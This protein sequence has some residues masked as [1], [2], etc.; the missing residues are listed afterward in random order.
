MGLIL[1]EVLYSKLPWDVSTVADWIDNI[2]KYVT[3]NIYSQPF[4]F[5]IRPIRS[6][7]IK[8]LI[9]KMLAIPESDRIS[10]EELIQDPI[11]MTI[12]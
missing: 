5:P 6:Q 3:I 7:A 10:F 8:D 4:T 9:S 12:D 11:I 1:F 2:K